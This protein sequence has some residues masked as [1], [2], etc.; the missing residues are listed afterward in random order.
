MLL[1]GVA[2]AWLAESIKC[3]NLDFDLGHHCTVAGIEPAL[4]FAL[5][6]SRE[7]A[8]DSP[9]LSAPPSLVCPF[10]FSQIQHR[11]NNHSS[12]DFQPGTGGHKKK[13]GS[14]TIYDE[15]Y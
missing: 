11:F 5:T 14:G 2:G 4:G 3:P 13:S 12:Q 8:W 1:Q 7:T 15:Y 6:D 9:F 10:S